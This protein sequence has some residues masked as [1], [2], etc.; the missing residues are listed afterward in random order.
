MI[1]MSRRGVRLEHKRYEEIKADIIDLFEECD[2]HHY[3]LNVFDIAK[4]LHYNVIPYSALPELK[5]AQC[6]LLSQDGCSELD[7]NP[8]THMYEYNIYYNDSLS[9]VQSRIYFTILHEIGHIRLGHLDDDIDKADIIKESE[10]NFYAGYIIAPPPLVGRFS[11]NSPRDLCR[12]FKTSDE[13]AG[14]AYDRYLKWLTCGRY[15]KDYEIHLLELF[16]VA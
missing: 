5:R 16:G 15:Y 13:V 12:R 4:K 8:D 2:V 7:I 1:I 10:A 9:I 11:C 3:P 14:Y 6:R